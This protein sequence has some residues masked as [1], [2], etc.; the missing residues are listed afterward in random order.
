[1]ISASQNLSNATQSAILNFHLTTRSKELKYR[2]MVSTTKDIL[3][4]DGSVMVTSKS[5]H[6]PLPR[7]KLVL[8]PSLK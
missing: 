8:E 6:E 5:E 7:C 1:M 2:K 3:H 4:K